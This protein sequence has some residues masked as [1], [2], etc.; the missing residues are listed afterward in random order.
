MPRYAPLPSVSLDPRSEAQLVQAAS[1]RVYEASNQTL[2]DFSS[3]NPLAALLEGQVF[4]QG[5]FLF[6]LNQLPEKLLLEWIGPFLGAMRRL[7]TASVARL[8]LTI[9]PSNSAVTVPSGSSFTTDLNLT[10]GAVYNF[11]TLETHIF[12]PGETVLFVPVYSEFVGS[13]YNV[14]A[15]SISGSSAVNVAGLSAINPQPATGGSDVET[16]QE[17]Q[18]RFFTLIRRKNPVSSQDWQDFFIDF[19]GVGTQTSVQPNRGSQY[20]YN[21]LTDYILPSGQV[22]FFVLGPGGVEL[23]Q[24]QLSRGQNVVNFSVPVGMTGN[25][26]PLTLSQVQYDITLEVDANS[27]YGTNFRKASLDFRDR[28]FQI[29]TPG[30]V[31]PAYTDPS[32]GDV[33]SA[34]NLTFDAPSRYVNPRIVTA[35]AFN[36]P[37]QLATNAALYTQVYAFE[38]SE[39]LLNQNDLVLETIPSKKYYP[40]VTS[41]TPY[42][43]DKGDQTIYNNLQMKQIQLLRAGSF[44][45]SDVVY[46]SPADGGD[47]KLRVILDNINIGSKTEIPVLISQGK[48]SGEKTYSPWVVGNSYASTVSGSYDPEIVE[49]DYIP[50]DGQFVPETPQELLIGP[51]SSFGT[52]VPGLSY[53]NGTYTGVPLINVSGTGSGA[54]ADITVVGGSVTSVTLVLAGGG[55]TPESIL[56]ASDASLGNSGSGNGFSVPVTAVTVPRVGGLVW[57]V[58]QNFTLNTPSNSTTSALSAG[59]LGAPVIPDVLSSGNSYL[60]GTWVTTPQIGS[61]PNAVADPYYNYVDRLKGGVDKFAYVLQG[62]VYEPNNLPTKD[63]FDLLVE[64]GIIKEIVVRN[65]DLGLPIYKYKPRFPVGTYLEYRDS[66]VAEP[67]YFVS[68]QYFTPNSTL[69]NDLI[70]ENLVIPLAYTP[71]QRISLAKAVSEGTITTPERMFRFFKGD[72]TFFRQGSTILSYTATTSVTPLFDFSVYL[73]NGV[74]VPSR[75]FAEEGFFTLPYVPYFNPTYSLYAED[76]IV[77]EDGRNF[78]RVMRAFF[79]QPKVTDWTN[80]VVNNTAR[81]QEYAG[82][83]LR[84]VNV[85]TCDEPIRSQF[86][87]DISS[88]KLGVAEITLIPKNAERFSNAS[89]SFSY[90]WENTATFTETPQLSWFTG[91]TYLYSPPNYRNGT[92][93]L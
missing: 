85:Y 88:I 14:P 79:P 81:I 63:Y 46:W 18:E 17:V 87:R 65:A 57:V 41:F 37:P 71:S 31:F 68:T 24:E 12:P 82:N 80:T 73:A 58:E 75:E 19:F 70:E 77:S 66:S 69:V 1:Q 22:S 11:V 25:L 32:V 49:Y 30:N 60:A 29:L 33:D 62:F 45:Q 51:I 2:N 26:Y 54:T 76:T 59:L 9:P 23:T 38:P 40:V 72:T 36:T 8:V 52:I 53:A 89:T 56:T 93:G 84:Y 44:L 48:I 7:G 67:Q 50:G 27:S 35:K 64:L 90:V 78:Y 15:N 16:Y 92:M 5:E 61:G 13:L 21:Y 34:F 91:T 10:G 42:S 4:A 28:L 47:G 86:G 83:L 55:Y 6:W 20:S 3:G 74:F 39:Q 43:S